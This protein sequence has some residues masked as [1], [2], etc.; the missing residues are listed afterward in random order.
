[1]SNMSYCR[2]E[3]TLSDV[4]ECLEAL[5]NRE[6][7]SNEEKENAKDLLTEVLRFCQQERIIDRF[8]LIVIDEVVN[9]CE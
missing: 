8:D 6:I 1:M 2:F 3:N 7:H 4:Q 5:E 9:E